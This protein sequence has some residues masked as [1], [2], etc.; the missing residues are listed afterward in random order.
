MRHGF[1]I[2]GE[3]TFTPIAPCRPSGQGLS[4]SFRLVDR[5]GHI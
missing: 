5:I 2:D 4:F 3:K 1:L